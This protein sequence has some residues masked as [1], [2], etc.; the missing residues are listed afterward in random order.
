[1]EFGGGR[2][3]MRRKLPEMRGNKG[4]PK[5]MIELERGFLDHTGRDR[6]F[7]ARCPLIESFE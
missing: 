2:A 3:A 4:L 1:M 5:R 7:A 6:G